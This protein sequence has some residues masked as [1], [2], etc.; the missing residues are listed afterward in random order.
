[1]K[2]LL[3]YRRILELGG[4]VAG[5]VL[6]ALGVV[7]LVMG[8]N[9]R[10]TVQSNLKEEYIFGSSDMYPAGIAEGVEEVLASQQKIAVAREKA[11]ADAIEF[12]SVAAPSCSVYDAE[13]EQGLAINNGDR[14]RCFAKYMRIHALESSG[15]LTYS[16]MGRF[17][18]KPDAP[19]QFTD[20]NGGTND[21]DYAAIN[22]DTEQPVANGARNTW[23]TE[24]A[25][26]SALN[27]AYAAEQIS[28]F[29]IVVGV[30]LLLSGIGFLVLALGGALRGVAAMAPKLERTAVGGPEPRGV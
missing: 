12:T 14:A 19:L 8:M 20:F 29:G 7:T 11:G 13:K 27:L 5:V 21:S 26:T 6:I 22:P 23:V 9:G 18:A 30:T 16:Q 25:L 10:S 17:V 1:M 15:G 4:I 24:T 3:N 28:L 2:A